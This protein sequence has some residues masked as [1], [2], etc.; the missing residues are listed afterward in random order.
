MHSVL[1]SH[2]SSKRSIFSSSTK[3]ANECVDATPRNPL[4]LPLDSPLRLAEEVFMDYLLKR[5]APTEESEKR[6]E[7]IFIK[8]KNIIEKTLGK[9]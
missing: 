7:A 9:C 4:S 3:D 1:S 2:S 8:I 5:V 6:R